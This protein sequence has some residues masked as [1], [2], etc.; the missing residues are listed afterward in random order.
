LVSHVYSLVIKTYAREICR[1]DTILTEA[2]PYTL[3]ILVRRRLT[4]PC[5][6]LPVLVGKPKIRIVSILDF[7]VVFIS[8]NIQVCIVSCD[9]SKRIH[10]FLKV[11]LGHFLLWTHRIIPFHQCV[12]GSRQETH[13]PYGRDLWTPQIGFLRTLVEINTL[14]ICQVPRGS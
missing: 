9:V 3:L 12:Y 7:G 14:P 2:G 8:T 5:P 10:E 6:D 13:F 1:I 4:F 11:R